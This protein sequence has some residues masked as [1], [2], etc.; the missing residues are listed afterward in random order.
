[1]MII[2]ILILDESIHS[3]A[4]MQE[5]KPSERMQRNTSEEQESVIFL[6]S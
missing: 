6:K 3:F 5:H 1:M 2:V 4:M